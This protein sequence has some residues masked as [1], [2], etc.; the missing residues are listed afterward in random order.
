M[1]QNLSLADAQVGYQRPI[2]VQ[3]AQISAHLHIATEVAKQISITSKNARVITARAGS[4]ACGYTAITTF[5][6]ELAQSTFKSSQKI[7]H[8][9]VAI[10]QL[11]AQRVKAQMA[12]DDFAAVMLKAKAARYIDSLQEV[13][14]RNDAAI[15]KIDT[16]FKCLL[17]ALTGELEESKKQVRTADI[18]VSTAKIEAS[19]SDG[20][21]TQLNVIAASLERDAQALKQQI[22]AAEKIINQTHEGEICVR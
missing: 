8:L 11:A 5:I 12:A 16:E 3:A 4:L 17:K 15:D 22:L 18:L 10:S 14:D 7:N 20:Y 19:K 9:A 6:E 2:F 21:V 1:D 13:V